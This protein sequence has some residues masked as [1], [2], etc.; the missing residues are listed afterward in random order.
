MLS[1]KPTRRHR[2][3]QRHGRPTL[4]QLIDAQQ[5]RSCILCDAL[6]APHVGVFIPDHPQQF[7]TEPGYKSIITYSLCGTCMLLKDAQERAVQRILR[8]IWVTGGGDVWL[9]RN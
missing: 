4:R 3:E 5:G 9:R 7:G 1:H 2:G 8:D 6:P